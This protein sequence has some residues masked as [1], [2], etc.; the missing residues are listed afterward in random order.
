MEER[1]LLYVAVHRE[2]TVIPTPL[3]ANGGWKVR[4]AYD[5]EQTIALL[6]S[7]SFDV[8]IAEVPPRS[9]DF[10]RSWAQIHNARPHMEWIALLPIC[11][12]QDQHLREAISTFFYDY[13]TVPVDLDRLFVTLG[14]AHGMVAIGEA[15]SR[16]DGADSSSHRI[17]GTSAAMRGVYH[18]IDKFA[19]VEAPVLITGESGTGKELVAIQIHQRSR[20]AAGPLV[21][22]NCGALPA[23]LIQSE[24]F[25]YE[26]GAFTGATVRRRGRIVE[27]AG[28][29]LFL[30]EIGE[31]PY[32]LQSNLLRVLQEGYIEPLGNGGR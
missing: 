8:G 27:A 28:G 9:Q 18:A 32:D 31:L 24:L 15:A 21:P 25:G 4:T 20:R 22:I 30:D 12:I 2:K 7:E 11:A 6:R 3:L 26:K 17:V 5:S 23:T 10:G 29:T 19:G 13:H 14:H 1:S 16:R